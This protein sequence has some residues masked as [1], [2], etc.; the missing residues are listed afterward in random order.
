MEFKVGDRIRLTD[1]AIDLWAREHNI[2]EVRTISR[3]DAGLIYVDVPWKGNNP[4]CD[5]GWVTKVYDYD[6]VKDFDIS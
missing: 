6:P 3:I 4:R 2:D 1:I 5:Q